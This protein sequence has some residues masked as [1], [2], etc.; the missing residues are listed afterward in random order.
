MGTL[1]LNHGALDKEAV[2]LPESVELSETLLFITFYSIDVC[3][4]HFST[5]KS[6]NK[7]KR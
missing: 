5:L 6:E 1:R 2:L 3:S 7:Q 4:V